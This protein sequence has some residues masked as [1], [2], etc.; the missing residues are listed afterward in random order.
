MDE[1]KIVGSLL[2]ELEAKQSVP[3]E[4]TP[5]PA[6]QPARIPSK[7]PKDPTNMLIADAVAGAGPAL[8]SLL[9][10][11]DT[12]Q[13]V[14]H[15]DRGNEYAKARGKQEE[16]TPDKLI[17]IDE[18]GEPINVNPY[19][20]LYQK[21]YMDKKEASAA[22]PLS[23][24]GNF[25]LVKVFNKNNGEYESVV[26]D[27][28]SGEVVNNADIIA[29]AGDPKITQVRTL[30]GGTKGFK[31]SP[32]KKGTEGAYSEAGIGD[33]FGSKPGNRLSAEEAKAG[34]K[35]SEK[36][37]DKK[38]KIIEAQQN[39]KQSVTMLSNPEATPEELAAGIQLML[40]AVNKER[41]SDPDAVRLKGDE[42]KSYKRA[43]E[44]FLQGKI[45][46]EISAS[47]RQGFINVANSFILASEGEK[48][49][50]DK[51]Y[52]PKGF[53]PP[54]GEKKVDTLKEGTGKSSWQ[55]RRKALKA[56]K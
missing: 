34:L 32:Y 26:F 13:V 11:A 43:L 28:S 55:E 41:L 47:T 6:E 21:P 48:R 44:D 4:T 23:K 29:R 39:A 8:L 56:I 51:N 46:G 42:F 54:A 24:K 5:Q 3:T 25:Q 53:L 18:N 50:I 22:A 35:S 31:V 37:K 9:G 49:A 20:A 40:K 16:I 52:T 36:A 14:G 45:A 15:F 27:T 30:E 12:R 38:V 7:F 33:Q 1:I 10:G 19:D 2:D 17:K